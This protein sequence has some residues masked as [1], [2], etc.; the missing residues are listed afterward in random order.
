MN[1][2]QQNSKGRKGKV[3]E[4]VEMPTGEEYEQLEVDMKLELVQRCQWHKREN[5]SE[6]LP[7]SGGLRCESDCNGAYEKP[8]YAEARPAL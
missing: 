6:Y 8:T 7:K 2:A 5:V 3:F 1:V 4:T